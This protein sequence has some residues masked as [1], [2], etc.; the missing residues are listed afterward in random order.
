M[1]LDITKLTL[2]EV[3]KIEEL[4]GMSVAA[5]GDE[6]RPKGRALAAMY[7]IAKRRDGDPKFTWNQAQEVPFDE[8]M[9][10]LGFTEEEAADPLDSSPASTKKQTAKK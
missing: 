8:A 9:A 4:S 1:A 7:F 5:I 3:A 2:G 6:E 10:Y